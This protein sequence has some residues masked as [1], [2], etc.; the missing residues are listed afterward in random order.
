MQDLPQGGNLINELGDLLCQDA[1]P[2]GMHT[3]Q[4]NEQSRSF[5]ST[6]PASAG[7]TCGSDLEAGQTS[8]FIT[9]TYITENRTRMQHREGQIGLHHQPVHLRARIVGWQGWTRL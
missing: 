9:S 8:Q 2:A 3:K 6:V 1:V 7:H 5:Q 4:G